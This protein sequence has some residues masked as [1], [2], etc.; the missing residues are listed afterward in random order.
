MSEIK[1]EMLQLGVYALVVRGEGDDLLMGMN[2]HT[3][4][5]IPGLE[6]LLHKFI[7]ELDKAFDHIY[8]NDVSSF[9]TQLE[10]RFSLNLH[11]LQENMIQNITMMQDIQ[12][13]NIM[14]YYLVITKTLEFIRNYIFQSK[15]VEWIESEY[16]L[17]LKKKPSAKWWDELTCLDS[18]CGDDYSLLYNLVFIYY[19]A[20][21]YKN[22]K[23][24]TKVKKTIM[25]SIANILK[26]NP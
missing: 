18:T 23:V 1:N 4:V 14:I 13:D 21:I 17:K 25:E 9:L 7:L 8:D 5:K 19:L 11:E 20:G 10:K 24:Q 3:Y 12:S 15:G 2:V 16:K 22:Q 6:N 26:E